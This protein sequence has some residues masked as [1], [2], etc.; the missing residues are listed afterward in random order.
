M[1]VELAKNIN[2]HSKISK[3]KRLLWEIVWTCFAKPTPRWA[4]NGWRCF[5]LRLFGAKVGKNVRV[6][7]GMRTWEPWK[8]TIGDNCWIDNDVYLYAVDRLSI[9][10]NVV[11]SEGAYI[12]TASHDVKSETFELETKPIVINDQS[13]IASRAIVLPGV[14]IG[15]GAVVAAGAVVTKDVEPWTIVGGN[16]ARQI[17]ARGK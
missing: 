17:R 4:L 15:E 1:K 9:G 13:W 8:L 12:C 14:T 3:A 2:R 10:S 6:Y 7:G 11:I 5:L 16:P